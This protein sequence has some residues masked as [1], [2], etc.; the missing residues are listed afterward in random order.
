M[1]KKYAIKHGKNKLT[2]KHFKTGKQLK[3]RK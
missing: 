3:E 2:F 1:A